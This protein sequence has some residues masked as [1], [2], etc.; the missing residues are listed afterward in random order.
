MKKE[1]WAILL[2]LF[3]WSSCGNKNRHE[4]NDKQGFQMDTVKSGGVQRMQ[5]SDSQ[6]DIKFHGKE[7]HISIHRAPCDSLTKVDDQAGESF[8]D[9]EIT[10]VITRSN[11]EKV[12][13][14]KF[15]KRSFSTVVEESFLA[16]SVLEG[17]VYDKVSDNGI[18]LAA[19]V[20]YPQTDL[21]VPLSITVTPD[22]RMSVAK[23]EI[24]DENYTG[25][26]S[27]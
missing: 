3:V 21:Y 15:T 13:S 7:Y 2:V 12:F 18:V 20:C 9:N 17:M 23:E 5:V 19:S 27:I 6:T 4:T 26:D 22:G 25:E 14:K 11:G 8:A 10:L 16:K 24:L 1:Y